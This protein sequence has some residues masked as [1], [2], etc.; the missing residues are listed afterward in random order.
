VLLV[1][2]N[3]EVAAGTEA[4]LTLLGHRVTYAPTA[5]DALR[6]IEGVAANDAFDLVISDIHMPGRL[7]GIDLAR[8]GRQTPD[9]LP[10]ILVTGYAESSTARAPSM[11]AYCRSRST[12]RCSTRFCWAFAKRATMRGTTAADLRARSEPR[13]GAARGTGNAVRRP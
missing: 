6:L 4:L 7:N 2:D 10:V 3:G 13:M 8:G 9:K 5:D 1:E 12:L 11:Y